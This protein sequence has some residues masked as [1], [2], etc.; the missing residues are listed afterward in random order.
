MESVSI[1]RA[2]KTTKALV[3]FQNQYLPLLKPHILNSRMYENT[4][5]V[6]RNYEYIGR[7]SSSNGPLS[8]NRLMHTNQNS[9]MRQSTSSCQTE[10]EAAP[11]LAALIPSEV[12]TPLPEHLSKLRQ[13]V[14]IASYHKEKMRKNHWNHDKYK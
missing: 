14:K 5:S 3:S 2:D 10:T 6:N 7:L 11:H 8:A 13:L 9:T 4:E 12:A 1:R